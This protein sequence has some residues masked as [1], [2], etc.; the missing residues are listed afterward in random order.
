MSVTELKE[1]GNAKFKAGNYEEALSVYT[2]ALHFGDIK[3]TDKAVIYKNRSMCNLKLEKY[4]EAI[5]D[6]S[7]SLEICPND[8]KA[9]YRRCLAYE[10]LGH[11]EEAYKDAA[12]MLKIDPKN[13]AIK[14]V[15]KRLTPVMKERAKMQASTENKVTQ[16]FDVLFDVN[17]DNEKRLQAGN[18]L[19]VLARESGGGEIIVRHDGIK[20]LKEFLM[21][22]KNPDFLQAGIRALSCLTNENRPRS[23]MVYHEIGVVRLG[24]LMAMPVDGLSTSVALLLHHMMLSIT[25]YSVFKGKMDAYDDKR[26]QGDPC[27]RPKWEI[28]EYQQKFLDE[29][30]HGLI[31]MLQHIKVS[32]C[33]R[34]ASMEL[35]LKTVTRK[36]GVWWTRRF[37]ESNGGVEGLLLIAGSVKQHESLPVTDQSRMHAS[38]L[39]TKIWEDLIGDKENDIFKEKVNGFFQELFSTEDLDSKVEAV[40]AIS[41]LLQGPFEIGNMILGFE[42]VN[43]IMLALAQS[44]RAIHQQIAVE[45]IVHSASK[46]D[47]CTGLLTE[48]VPVLKHLYH[49]GNN[50]NIKV[51]A[52]VGLCKLGSFQGS[53]ATTR[54][55][56]EGSTITLAKACR[57]FLTNPAGDIQMK[58]WATEGL[59]YLTLDADV[60]EEVVN[61]PKALAAIIQAAKNP[62]QSLVYAAATL[63][64]NLTNSF[65]KQEMSPEMVELAKYAKQ[66]VPEE[67][68]KDKEEFVTERI[69]KLVEAGM[70]GCLLSLFNTESNNTREQVSRVFITVAN[71]EAYRGQIVQA[72]GVK[73]LLSLALEK[74]TD[75]GKQVAAQTL[76]KLAITQDPNITFTGQRMY[77]VV[78]PLI[79]LLDVE[80]TGLQNFEALMALTNLSSISDSVRQRIVS[81]K[82]VPKIEYYMF[83][84]HDLIQRASIECMCNMVM[85]ENVAKS[86]DKENDK[87]KFMV[88][89]CADEDD[90]CVRAAS[91]ALAILTADSEIVCKKILQVNKWDELLM[92]VIVNESPEIQHRGCYIIRNMVQ[93]SK[94]IAETVLEGQVL[95]VLMAVSV[96]EAPDRQPARKCCKETLQLAEEYKIIQENP[97]K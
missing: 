15:L 1:D 93:T 95:D 38:L 34:D 83:E 10:K 59:A 62:S 44:D 39:L 42:G 94:E 23:E 57:K 85:N 5:D 64:V 68:A 47:R 43:G 3:D 65:D 78:R 4:K 11:L 88:L 96:L 53:D 71:N 70:I 18:N 20:R 73:V 9:L 46:K 40:R 76:A 60:K 29:V 21:N 45:A 36:T 31:K 69:R 16:M 97:N 74:N 55:M 13:D 12:F 2:D 6:A 51:R 37:I 58:Q 90:K 66:H 48:A 35:M 14:P 22:E 17:A 81:E 77:E 52:L 25:E 32:A 26:R 24:Q 8:P 79:S 33:G 50:D 87:V 61:D 49:N 63:F 30:F 19:V 7:E 72:G 89:K 84:D 67:H 27:I 91:G 86:Y 82:G 56:A 28:D 54:P 41:M 92:A 80:R 75:L